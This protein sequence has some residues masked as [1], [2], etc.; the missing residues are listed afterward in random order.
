M[1]GRDE[2]LKDTEDTTLVQMEEVERAIRALPF[3]TKLSPVGA[4]NSH[5][6]GY[7]VSLTCPSC[8]EYGSC[9]KKQEPPVQVSSWHPTLHACWLELLKRLQ[10]K[11]G[12]CAESLTNKA[13]ADAQAAAAVHTPN[14]LQAMMMFQQAQHRAKAAQDHA[15]AA[16]DQAKV[17]NKVALQAE[18]DNDADQKQLQELQ[19]VMEPKRARTLAATA[20]DDEECEKQSCDD[21]D[22]P[23]H[24]R[25]ATRIQGSW[26]CLA[27]C[28]RSSLSG[29]K[30]SS[31]CC[32]VKV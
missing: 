17:A 32:L 24:H 9:G 30:T 27:V 31:L 3:V 12:R 4:R 10:E 1:D 6:H 15:K 26:M 16:Q 5:G 21:W 23:D 29:R 22:L 18:K 8:E 19:R 2:T 14:V 20:D 28:A 11:H 25:E 7:R 13:A